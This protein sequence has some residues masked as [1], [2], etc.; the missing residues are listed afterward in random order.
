MASDVYRKFD[1]VLLNG[2]PCDRVNIV[3]SQNSDYHTW[4]QAEDIHGVYW[5]QADGKPVNYY[6]L[7]LKVM[8]GMLKNSKINIMASDF[9]H[10]QLSRNNEFD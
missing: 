7:R 6:R 3:T 1:D 2:M 10:Y 4:E 5:T 8:E 9:N